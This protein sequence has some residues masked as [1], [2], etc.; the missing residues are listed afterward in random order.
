MNN[1]GS[2][3]YFSFYSTVYFQMR[4]S[5][6][7]VAD[8][9][10]G[11]MLAPGPVSGTETLQLGGI[12]TGGGVKAISLNVNN[13]L[14]RYNIYSCSDPGMNPCHTDENTTY[15]LNTAGANWVSGLNKLT[16]CVQDLAESGTS[17]NVKC[18]DRW[19]YR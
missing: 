4:D 8:F 12:D 11:T 13:V 15:S 16:V 17:P 1:C 7:P 2:G 18:E 3:A 9:L 5:G 14:T 6:I 19:V 10:G